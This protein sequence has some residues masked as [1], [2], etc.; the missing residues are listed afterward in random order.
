[1]VHFRKPSKK[2]FSSL[3]KLV[4]T[5][6]IL[7]AIK[8][9]Q[10]PATKRISDSF[11]LSD[12]DRLTYSYLEDD[13]RNVVEITTVTYDVLIDDK[14]VTAIYYDGVHGSLHRHLVLSAS[15]P[16]ESVITHDGVKVRGSQRKLLN[17]AIDDIKNDL[18]YNFLH[19]RR[20][21]MKR[22]KLVDSRSTR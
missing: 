5:R 7:T 10:K 13:K 3:Q 4:P 6:R 19:Y 22:S 20:E 18:K 16:D 15:T 14:W 17:W 1:M 12:E 9:K 21:F 8:E 2:R 11:R